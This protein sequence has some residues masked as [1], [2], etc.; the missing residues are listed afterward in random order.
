MGEGKEER[1][2]DNRWTD[3]LRSFVKRISKW[4]R[5]WLIFFTALRPKLPSIYL[6]KTYSTRI[7]PHT[8]THNPQTR[9]N[10][11]THT[12]TM[13][14]YT[15]QWTTVGGRHASLYSSKY[16]DDTSK[17]SPKYTHMEKNKGRKRGEIGNTKKW[18]MRCIASIHTSIRAH[19]YMH[20]H[21]HNTLHTHCTYWSWQ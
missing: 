11:H 4:R 13:R 5:R 17:N 8:H 7:Q 1:V 18:W 3:F 2:C 14:I 12:H 20:S 15:S 6:V 10:T 19:L 9:T 16:L 21:F